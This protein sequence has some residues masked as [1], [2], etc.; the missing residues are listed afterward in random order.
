MCTYNLYAF[1]FSPIRIKNVT[2]ECFLVH[3]TKDEFFSLEGNIST[4]QGNYTLLFAGTAGTVTMC[5]RV[6]GC[7]WA[8]C[9]LDAMKVI[10]V[11][12]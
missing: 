10:G 1:L 5:S 8:L 6:G 3:I 11:I 9:M 2:L 4:E 12:Y 7:H